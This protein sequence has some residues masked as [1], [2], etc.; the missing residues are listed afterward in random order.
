MICNK[1]NKEFDS[2]SKFCPY[3][4]TPNEARTEAQ[5]PKQAEY[6][7]PV[8]YQQPVNYTQPPVASQPTV[9]ANPYDIPSVLLCIL[10]FFEPFLGLVLYLSWYR[11][12]PKRAKGVGIAA[13][14]SAILKVLG[15]IIFAILSTT[16]FAV[17]FED[18]IWVIEDLVEEVLWY[19]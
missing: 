19:F 13:L 7:P 3:C 16:V 2:A 12:Y 17:F 5:A 18:L 8:S 9:Q 1:C 14:I 10:S 6:T 11:E 4:G 15:L